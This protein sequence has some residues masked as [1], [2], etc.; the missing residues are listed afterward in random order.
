[1][2]RRNIASLLSRPL[3]NHSARRLTEI[4]TT[5]EKV[6][7]N[8]AKKRVDIQLSLNNKKNR[9]KRVSRCENFMN[10]CAKAFDQN[11]GY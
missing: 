1:V 3:I 5:I 7:Y 2:K 9:F 8:S 10:V 4:F 11:Y 6:E